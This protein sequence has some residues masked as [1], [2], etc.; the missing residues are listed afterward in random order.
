MT[1]TQNKEN[2][3]MTTQ[4]QEHLEHE[5]GCF[6]SEFEA[7]YSL[8]RRETR[9]ERQ[10]AEVSTLT[11]AGKFVVVRQHEVFCGFTDAILG[12]TLSIVS[13][14]ENEADAAAIVGNDEE[15]GIARPR[16]VEIEV[17]ETSQVAALQLLFKKGGF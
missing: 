8:S 5:A 6:H 11:K 7:A 10:D 4:E 16:V 9:I 12:V 3:N 14:H 1:N 2:K 13:V 15:L 17:A